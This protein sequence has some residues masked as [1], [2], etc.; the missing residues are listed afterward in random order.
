MKCFQKIVFI[1]V[2]CFG[3]FKLNAQS[4]GGTTSGSAI[5]CAAANSGFINSDTSNRHGTIIR[6]ESSVD[7]GTTWTPVF[8]ISSQLSYN[9]LLL[10]TCY[11]AVLKDGTFPEAVS[12]M[13]CISIYPASV[14]GTISG[15]GTFCIAPGSGAG[16]LNLTGSIRD[17]L[18]WQ[19]STNG[20]ASWTSLPDTSTTLNYTNIN[21]NTLYW[22]IVRKGPAQCTT[23][24]STQASFTFDSLT[25]T[26]TIISLDTVCPLINNSTLNLNN[27]VG[28]VLGWLSSIDNGLTWSPIA[29]TTTSEPFSGLVQ[30]TWYKAIVKNGTCATDTSGYAAI[31]IVPN[32]VSAG[33]DTTILLGQSVQL[34]GTGFGTA[35]WTPST[36]LDS[37]N[38]FKPTAT[39]TT[40]TV[41]LLTVTDSHSC[42]SKDSVL[43]D[44][45][46]LEF[47]GFVSNLFTP[48]GDGINDAWYIKDIQKYPDN[49]VFVYNI[50]GKLVYTKKGYTNDWQGTYN[51]S[52]LPDGTYF[53]VLRFNDSGNIT[54]GSVDILRSK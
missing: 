11:R 10:S 21:Q 18:Y 31:T 2:I 3:V 43:I 1:F 35:V 32:P 44:I 19:Y 39:P 54:K 50:Y 27:N 17:T 30:T 26:G 40:S 33:N 15:A 23:D 9:G 8:N 20:G 16:V 14:G 25:V 13:S 4:L 48:N 7:G 36:G 5:Y 38:I 24:T 6:W 49:E 28:S 41:Y 47:N 29:D 42:I 37:T 22:A 34:N 53:Y 52:P 12:T 51:G 46:L 45:F